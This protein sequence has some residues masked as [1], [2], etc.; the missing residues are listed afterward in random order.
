MVCRSVA[1]TLAALMVGANGLAATNP[2]PAKV[3]PHLVHIGYFFAD[4][5]YGDRKNEVFPYTNLYVAVPDAYDT[6]QDW[7]PPLRA[8]LKS[9][10]DA[11]KDIYFSMRKWQFGTCGTPLSGFTPAMTWE[12]IL[13]IFFTDAQRR[14]PDATMAGVWERVKYVEVHHETTCDSTT[15]Q[16]EANALSSLIAASTGLGQKPLG[17]M[18]SPCQG[19]NQCP[20]F[21]QKYAAALSWVGIEAYVDPP[22]SSS[23]LDTAL[24]NA[25]NNVQTSKDVVM[26]GMAYDRAGLWQD[27]QTLTLLQTRPYIVANTNCLPP[28]CV[29]P[30]TTALLLFNYTRHD[31]TY[32]QQ[33]SASV[34]QGGT[35]LHLELAAP[36]LQI[37][38]RI[39]ENTDL[40]SDGVPDFWAALFNIANANQD[41]DL[42][43]LTN[44][45]EYQGRAHPKGLHHYLLGE[46]SESSFFD[47]MVSVGNPN[48]VPAVINVVARPTSGTPIVQYLY[49]PALHRTRLFG[50]AL[51]I[52]DTFSVSIESDVSIAVDRT[53]RWDNGGYGGHSSSAVSDPAL[54][55]YFAE[56]VSATPFDVFYLLYNPGPVP[57]F[58]SAKYLRNTGSPIL[59]SYVIP[60][61]SRQ[62]IW[63]DLEA[64]ELES[65]EFGAVFEVTNGTPVVAERALYY[66]TLE[67]PFAAG[68]NVVGAR[69]PQLNWYLA[70]GATGDF[71]DC[72]VLLANPN[73]TGPPAQVTVDFLLPGGGVVS[74]TRSVAPGS[75]VTIWA[76]TVPGLSS[77]AFAIRVRATNGIPVLAERAMWWPGPASAGWAEAHAEVGSAVAGTRWLIADGEEGGSAGTT[78]YVLVANMGDATS[79]IRVRLLLNE[80]PLVSRDYVLPA[81]AR[82]SVPVAGDFAPSIGQRYAVEVLSLRPNTPGPDPGPPVVVEVSKY[83]N[84]GGV[85]WA[86][87]TAHLA[88][89]EAAC[90]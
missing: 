89:C 87:G 11:G 18:Q 28:A 40:N 54:A 49:L 69:Q 47:T 56:G 38:E 66:S 2:L 58:V 72:F 9:A 22:S 45:Q 86:A 71:F 81:S 4:G 21:D 55:W 82:L 80:R 73:L 32:L 61:M 20:G 7:R 8:A 88:R 36:H 27:I 24:R 74:E 46:G 3:N 31:Q 6:G 63:A 26:V 78:T 12:N 75:R 51:G 35:R 48:P 59:K 42:D 29:T 77:A 10:R 64:P 13:G 68:H 79:L 44:L 16:L 5:R 60:A 57:A 76:D 34:L 43:G 53:M 85:F 41:D 19:Q 62:T 65:A 14:Q 52:N 37:A 17:Y 30:R 39:L 1:A 67:Q 33:P 15:M 23:T 83:W 25:I 70:E 84:A 50:S 90:Q